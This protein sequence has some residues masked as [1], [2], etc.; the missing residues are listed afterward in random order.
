MQTFT[1]DSSLIL[2]I[3][4]TGAQAEGAFLPESKNMVANAPAGTEE[5]FVTVTLKE[6][7]EGFL[8][9]KPLQ[10]GVAA[11]HIL[12]TGLTNILVR[13]VCGETEQKVWLYVVRP[14]AGEHRQDPFRPRFHFNPDMFSLNDP[15]GLCY[16]KA[17]GEYH[18]YF[19][20]DLPFAT[21][22]A[23]EGNQKS[24][25]HAVSFDLLHWQERPLAICPDENGTIW[26]G[27]MVIDKNNTSG[28]FPESVHP[29]A[30]LVALY[31]YFGATKP[32][33]GQCSIGIAYSLD[34][35]ETFVKP[36]KEPIIPNTNNM[37]E[38]GFRDPKVIWLPENNENGGVW[39]L[40]GAGGR[41]HLF[42]SPNL[43]N[44]RHERALN[45]KDGSPLDSEC[46]DI[47]PLSAE[48]ETC[49]FYSGGGVFYM[50][51]ALYRAEDGNLDFKITSEK[52]QPVNGVSELFPGTGPFPEMYAA[53]TFYNDPHDRRVEMCWMRDLFVS[54][55]KPWYNL[56]S[57][58][59]QVRAVK[60]PQGIRLQKFPVAEVERL[61]KTCLLSVTDAVLQ[62]QTENPLAGLAPRLFEIE[63]TLRPGTAKTVALRL[64]GT[65]EGYCEIRYDAACGRLITDKTALPHIDGIYDTAVS[66]V[67][68][69]LHLRI[70]ADVS[71]LDVFA[72]QGEVWHNGLT[73]A[74]PL[75]KPMRLYA[76][77]G[78]AHIEALHVYELKEVLP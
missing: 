11:A 70:L 71:V 76:S 42:S 36:F 40:V 68:G 32:T 47:Y 35:G 23:V 1:K 15:N 54:P 67:R 46:P 56:I 51:G 14:W 57:L 30:R 19:Q 34:G 16:N 24:W 7:A 13:A 50:E 20:R 18:L 12:Y 26:S 61:R 37:Y 72:N 4:F 41:A 59:L 9:D 38:P 62:P 29:D 21:P 33:N 43:I 31:T 60:T 69:A 39:V 74:D 3:S 58:P 64:F 2:G 77:G 25:G 75:G 73:Y 28:F 49:W 63:L 5:V 17:T 22:Y 66:L 78:T 27:S 44:W 65:E 45:E 55:E 10:S 6:G 52:I 53:Q 8:G 48:G